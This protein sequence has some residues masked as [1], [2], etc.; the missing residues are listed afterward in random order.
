MSVHSQINQLVKKEKAFWLNCANAFY[1][2]FPSMLFR[3]DAN[4]L[5]ESIAISMAIWYNVSFRK[6]SED[7][8]DLEGAIV[9]HNLITCQ[10]CSA[11]PGLKKYYATSP[12]SRNKPCCYPFTMC[13]I[14]P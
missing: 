6:D 13:G 7:I 8:L 12:L 10:N 9:N 11:S 2:L 14:D 4:W 1:W 3:S 5:L